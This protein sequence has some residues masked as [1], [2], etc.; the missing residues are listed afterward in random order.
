MVKLLVLKAL[1]L[2]D[3]LEEPANCMVIYE[4][5]VLSG[6]NFKVSAS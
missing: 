1:L 2:S 6:K 4:R 5:A 3:T